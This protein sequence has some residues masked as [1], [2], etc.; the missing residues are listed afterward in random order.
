[1]GAIRGFFVVVISVLLFLSL[2]SVTLLGIL[3][4]SLIYDHFSVQSTSVIKDLVN[5][6]GLTSAVN[7][8][9]PIMK[10]YCQ[11]QNQTDYVLYAEGYTIDIPC[12]VISEGES[13]IVDETIKDVVHDIYYKDYGCDFLNC[14]KSAQIPLFLISE[15]AYTFCNNYF[16]LFI[17][18]S[19][20]LAIALFIFT[21]KK[22]NTFIIAGVLM[23]IPALMFFK[24]D[25]F[26]SLFS[27]K[28]LFKI[29]G[30]FFSQSFPVSLNILIVGIIL[31]AIGIVSKIFNLGFKIQ[32][33]I[34]KFKPVAKGKQK[35]IPKK[36]IQ[37]TP[38]TIQKK[39]STKAKPKIKF[40]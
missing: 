37:I 9:Y 38:K 21:E 3:S 26:L 7:S 35:T 31:L 19:L 34:S 13:A 12:N 14:F 25:Y 6:N 18:A 28:I 30:I 40:K 32:E 22:T 36:K 17:L 1:M 8:A 20:I 16:Y 5:T 33:F 24:L 39:K 29:L 11:S 15:K 27:G 23:V 2:F 4:S 10:I